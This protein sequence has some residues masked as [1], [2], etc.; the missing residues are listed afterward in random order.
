[1]IVSGKKLGLQGGERWQIL[2]GC[3]EFQRRGIQYILKSSGD[4][5]ISL[6]SKISSLIRELG[7][8]KII[9]CA[10]GTE[11]FFAEINSLIHVLKLW[12]THLELQGS[13]E[14]FFKKGY[15]FLNYERKNKSKKKWFELLG[16]RHLHHECLKKLAPHDRRFPDYYLKLT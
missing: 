3:E 14:N 2:K 1:L 8:T 11:I 12:D 10:G 6:P 7:E 13:I 4:Q 5:I 15:E 9:V 16:W